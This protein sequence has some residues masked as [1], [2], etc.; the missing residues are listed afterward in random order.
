MDRE[1]LKEIAA[2]LVKEYAASQLQLGFRPAGLHPYYGEDGELIYFKIRLKHPDGKKWIRPFHFDKTT[3]KYV[4]QEPKFSNK[5]PLYNLLELKKRPA[6]PVFIHEGELCCDKSSNLGLLSVTSGSVTSAQQTDWLAL[7]SRT[8]YIWPDNNIEGFKYAD[9][10]KQILLALKCDI[11]IIDVKQLNI[12]EKGDIVDWMKNHP[13]AELNDILALPT[14][15]PMVTLESE[16]SSNAEEVVINLATLSEIAYQHKRKEAAKHL[17]ISVTSLDDTVKQARKNLSNNSNSLFVDIVPWNEPVDAKKL[18][19]DLEKIISRCIVFPSDYEI[20][21]VVLYIIHTH[22]IDAADCSPIL[23]ISSPEKRCGKS[24]L[25][26]LLQHLVNRPLVAS[27]ISY[28]AV[29]RSIEKWTPSLLLDESDTFLPNNDEIRGVINSGHTRSSAF[30]I[31]CMGDEHEPRRFN[32][33]CPKIIA[34]IGHLPETIEDRSIIVQLRRKLNTETKDKLR[35]IPKSELEEL[36][37]KCV[38]FMTDNIKVLEN[39]KPSIPTELNDRA[40]DNWAPLLAIALLAGSDWLEAATNA[41]IHLCGTKQEPISLGVELLQDIKIIFDTK[42]VHRLST[43][44]LLE[45]L[46]L[47]NEALW[48]TYNRGKPLSA[49]QLA[50]RLKEFKIHS[51]DIRLPP[52]NRNL[53]GYCLEDFTEAF[54]CYIPSSIQ[55]SNATTLQTSNSIGCSNSSKSDKNYASRMEITCNPHEI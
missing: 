15:M 54:S 3:N 45:A 39:V 20:K 35:D 32:T 1:K 26:S 21:A 30:V 53:K 5:K 31:R 17:R 11:K 9:E 24:T 37:R 23:N 18:L 22:C 28:A 50:D 36:N 8:V 10:V 19:D 49:R 38:R 12:P 4:M 7:T 48:S 55:E 13:K 29:F 16:T 52:L 40:A 27:N 6:D 51:K 47:D 25:L 33:W 14:I 44:E 2:L 34:G 42:L 41:A 46:C 43:N